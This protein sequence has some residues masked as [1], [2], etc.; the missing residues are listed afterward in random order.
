MKAIFILL[1]CVLGFIHSQDME[2]MEAMDMT[3]TVM[4]DAQI[5]QDVS[6]LSANRGRDRNFCNFFFATNGNRPRTFFDSVSNSRR[7]SNNNSLQ[8]ERADNNIDTINYAG[9]ACE[10]TTL[11]IWSS[12]NFRGSSATWTLKR[13][14][15]RIELDNF[16]SDNISSYKLTLA[17]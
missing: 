4:T 17:R 12:T 5:Q 1:V 8:G 3:S 11:K 10:G 7:N 15:G 6:A 16:W 9:T 2:D 13:D 14:Q